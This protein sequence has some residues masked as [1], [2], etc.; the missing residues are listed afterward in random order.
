MMIKKIIR[1][2]KDRKEKKKRE[3]RYKEKIERLK[4]QDPFTYKH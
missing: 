4:K 1:W 3:L 2:F